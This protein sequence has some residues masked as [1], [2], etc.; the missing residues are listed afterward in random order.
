MN[1]INKNISRL[2]LHDSH[3]ENL[4]R[5]ADLTIATFDW[6]YLRDFSE[7]G[8]KKGIVIGKCKLLINGIKNEEF[9]VYREGTK[10]DIEK[11]PEDINKYWDEIANTEIDE[12][13]K[14]I[15][16][17]GMFTRGSDSNWIEWKFNY[18][19]VKLE[20]NSFVTSKEWED[21]KLPEN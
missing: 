9:R 2:S 14:Q 4:E 1:S 18:D 3:L 8:Y 15:I 13:H 17:D 12:N 21:G 20:W 10:Y 11:T 6:G 7:S 5:K 16:L 19:S